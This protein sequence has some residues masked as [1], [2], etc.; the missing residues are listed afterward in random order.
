MSSPVNLYS[1]TQTR[2]SEG[3]R[4]A[5][6]RAVVGD[7]QRGLDPTTNALQER[8]AE[9]LGFPAAVF[10]PSGS[11]CNEI[12]LRLHAR[13]GGDELLLDRTAHPVNSEAGGPA[14]L[15]GLMIRTLDG[16][17]GVFT[18]EQVEAAVR[19]RGTRYMPRSRVVSVEQTTNIAGGHVW[20]LE[21]IRGVLSV[22][23]RHGLR[24]HMD[25]ARLMNAV[26][27]SGVSA[28]DF[29]SGFDTAWIDFTKGLGAPV[30]AVLA[31]SRELIDEAWRWKQMLGGAFRQSGIVAAGCLYA[32]DHNVDR[33]AE[34]HSNARLLADGLA[35]LP[36]VRLDPADVETNIVVF[37]V[38]DAPG[39]VARIA[40]RVELQAFDEHRVRAVTHLDVSRAGV[41]LALE[42]FATELG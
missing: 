8:V 34:D 40:D 29:A 1:D 31:G 20:P 28:S 22:A 26:V 41:E 30:G 24:A 21:T 37:S 33:L 10:L 4:E 23:R 5:I 35:S 18:P 39:L 6:A 36:G 17:G 38:D 16:A 15:S 32:L 14:V 13:P 19:T 11:M 2:P 7:E 3:M 12:A 27:A 9:L 42:A 25:G